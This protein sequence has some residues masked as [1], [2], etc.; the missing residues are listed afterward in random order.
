LGAGPLTNTAV[1]V[2][3]DVNFKAQTRQYDTS[4]GSHS[5]ELPYYA[6]AVHD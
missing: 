5:F 6:V 2:S 1:A 3:N 4:A